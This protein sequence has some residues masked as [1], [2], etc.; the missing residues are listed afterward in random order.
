MRESIRVAVLGLG[1]LGY[2][3]AENLSTRI[4]GAK[5][6]YVVD[7]IPGRA[8]QVA[9]ELS[10]PKWTQNIDEVLQDDQVDAIVI[11]TPT[12]THA[13]LIKKVAKA[14]KHIFVEKPLTEY[15]EDADEVIQTIDENGVFCQ[16]GFMR[17]FDPAYAEAKK[18]I[19]T[20]DIG[21]PL[22]FKGM[23][24]DGNIPPVE[25]IKNSGGIFLDL[26]IHEFDIARYLMSAEITEVKSVGSILLHEFM[27]ELNDADHANSYLTFDSGAS[28]D[29][30][31]SWIA[32]Y[33]YD[34]RGEVVGSEG[35]IQIGT[36]QQNQVHILNKNGSTHDIVPDF[37]TKFRDA[38]F[39][40]M[41]HFIDSLRNN[42]TPNCNAVDGKI[43][44][45]VATAATKSFH[46]GQTIKLL[47]GN[48]D[49]VL[50]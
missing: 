6:E 25:F 18:R 38:Y 7:P 13:E 44:L 45:E 17:R 26:A 8:E 4:K 11:V 33:G 1:R 48:Q 15:V 3:H 27:A 49:K 47:S 40:E 31:A 20:G 34:I 2:W 9:G 43:A 12:S 29:I 21:K 41:E 32:P 36:M 39:L 19:A 5:L 24:R 30:E 42:Q 10:V 46:T 35:T 22:Y 14:Q 28:G 16:V 50:I 23:S 37:P